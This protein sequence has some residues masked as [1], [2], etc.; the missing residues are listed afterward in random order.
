MFYIFYHNKTVLI[1]KHELIKTPPE[2]IKNSAELQDEDQLT[3][4]EKASSIPQNRK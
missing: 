2:L 1:K 3:K 4:S